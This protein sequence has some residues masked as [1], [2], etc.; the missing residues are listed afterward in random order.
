[1]L[2]NILQN[3]HSIQ[4]QNFADTNISSLHFDSRNVV[5]GSMFFAIKGT[6]T[7][8][9][10]YIDKAIESGATVIVYENDG[11]LKI[12][13]A[14]VYVQVAD[15][16][17]AM[18]KCAGNFYNN[19]SEKLKLIGVTGTNGKTTTVTLLY[20]LFVEM[21]EKCGLISTIKY[22]VNN[23]EYISTHTTPNIIKLNELL[24]AM[25]DEGCKYA[26]ME[27]SSHAIHQKRI[28]GLTFAGGVFTNISHDHLDYHKTYKEYIKAKKLFFDG[29]PK[30]A[31]ALTNIDD[32]NGEFMLQNTQAKK[33]RYAVKSLAD[34]K[35]KINF[36]TIDGMELIFNNNSFF[37][38]IVGVYNCYNL[39]VTYAVALLLNKNKV[40]TL[41]TLSVITGA[42]GR[43]ET[44][45]DESSGKVAIVDYAHTPDAL[46]KLLNAV[47]QVKESNQNVITV[48]GCGG[49]RD[50][51]K[52]PIMAKNAVE[53]SDYVL[54]T[55]DNP[56][57]E[58]PAQILK[59]MY[60]GVASDKTENVEIIEDR[61]AAITKAITLAS[62]NDLVIVAGKGHETYQEI[63]GIK[64]PFDDVQII[65]Q[66]FKISNN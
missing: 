9:H 37:T 63:N 4:Q 5:Q 58:N 31:F 6:V 36:H 65:K 14:V 48:V 20:N 45:R 35:A 60:V 2:S 28:A 11:D 10:N 43:F 27:V 53:L 13:N 57:T 33:Q 62:F 3:V 29:L 44:V 8:G 56:R 40:L 50:K 39:L 38:S 61:K 24:N 15:S 55:S 54:L 49:D 47:N 12:N 21:G 52:R 17:T 66:I 34:F 22:L 64:H 46:S 18:A 25:V 1:K 41:N 42:K 7:D 30:T 23:K 16:S 59:D 32:K 51:A 26:F 19:P